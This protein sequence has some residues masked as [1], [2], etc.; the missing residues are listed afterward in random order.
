MKTCWMT[1]ALLGAWLLTQLA[2]TGSDD[3][4][5]GRNRSGGSTSTGGLGAG[6]GSSS[7]SSGSVSGS[8]STG[9]GG[10]SSSTS[11]GGESSS[12][13]GITGSTASSTSSTSSGDP[14]SSS[15]SFSSSSSS[16]A[17][18]TSSAS[19]SSSAASSSSSSSASSSSSSSSSSGGTV[20]TDPFSA[21]AYCDGLASARC[22]RFVKCNTQS[23][24]L[25][26][27]S[28]AGCVSAFTAGC[29]AAIPPVQAAVGVSTAYHQSQFDTCMAL[30]RSATCNQEPGW[31]T[32]CESIFTGV[33]GVG[34]SCY[35]LEQCAPGTYCTSNGTQCGTCQ[36]RVGAN[37][38]CSGDECI[39]GYACHQS[40]CQPISSVYA[41]AGETCDNTNG[42]FC[43]GDTVCSNGTCATITTLPAGSSCTPND[44]TS[45]CPITQNCVGDGLF[46]ITGTCTNRPQLNDV[47]DFNTGAIY[48]AGNTFCSAWEEPTSV[49][50]G[51]CIARRGLNGSCSDPDLTATYD[52]LACQPQY[53]CTSGTCSNPQ[54]LSP[55]S[56]P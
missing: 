22:A 26:Y 4:G 30:Y 53:T 6:V 13:G 7:S 56:C 43:E 32:S 49:T 50:Q 25:F 16:P 9:S 27:D 39:D 38:T 37:G 28:E 35:A 20:Q 15:S 19:S 23:V 24:A 40:R 54:A 45:Q 55:I 8:S 1:R 44:S 51:T 10:I 47:C 52:D 12:S 17:S 48:C 21:S 33:R 42:P 36:Q 2:C 18:S 11:S 5:S 46:N 41:G 3:D 34:Q 14:T 31:D 29:L